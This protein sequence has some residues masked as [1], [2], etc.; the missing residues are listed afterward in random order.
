MPKFAITSASYDC[1]RDIVYI[2]YVG[3]L[4]A[5]ESLFLRNDFSGTYCQLIKINNNTYQADSKI[6]YGFILIC[7]YLTRNILYSFAIECGGNC[8]N[9][10]NLSDSFGKCKVNGAD[11]N[12]GDCGN[13]FPRD[14]VC[15]PEKCNGT[16][17]DV[18][19]LASDLKQY[20]YMSIPGYVSCEECKDNSGSGGEVPNGY[21]AKTYLTL[22]DTIFHTSNY[23]LNGHIEP[24]EWAYIGA[25]LYSKT[26]GCLLYYF[27]KLILSQPIPS[28]Y[29]IKVKYD[30]KNGI[31]YDESKLKFWINSSDS[32]IPKVGTKL[33]NGTY[34]F[35]F[36]LKVQYIDNSCGIYSDVITLDV[37]C[38]SNTGAPGPQPPCVVQED[39]TAE[40]CNSYPCFNYY[41]R[42][43]Y[44]ITLSV[45]YQSARFFPCTDRY[46]SGWRKKKTVV[47]QPFTNEYVDMTLVNSCIRFEITGSDSCNR[48][49]W[50]AI[51]SKNNKFDKF[52]F[53]A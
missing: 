35:C 45:Y 23:I 42:N 14:I 36:K 29:K 10:V 27:N 3:D 40:V 9:A 37:N 49:G 50:F 13:T 39:F 33:N 18:K 20:Y 51:D 38:N 1:L 43:N 22:E 41:N 6:G 24:T 34:K 17:L 5:N 4:Q 16:K 32:K 11:F 15:S 52:E 26:T 19:L 44:P 47:V 28:Y 30:C 25:A 8:K 2:Q 46:N 21:P 7:S 12:T 53:Y 48:G 31:Q